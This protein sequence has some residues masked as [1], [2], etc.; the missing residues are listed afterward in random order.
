MLI[1]Q[2]INYNKKSY[3]LIFLSVFGL[4]FLTSLLGLKIATINDFASPVWI[5]SG[6][7]IGALAIYGLRIAPAIYISALLINFFAGM[8]LQFAAIVAFGNMT[9]AIIGGW[10]IILLTRKNY[11]KSYTE[12][13]AIFFSAL[14][15]TLISAAMGTYAS[16]IS[17]AVASHQISYAWYTWWSGDA[18]GTLIILPLVFE[19]FSVKKESHLRKNNKNLQTIVTFIVLGDNLPSLYT[20]P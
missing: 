4:Y 13:I 12:F 3:A 2:K 18:I 20:K 7:A 9:E 6:I 19:L 10:L 1:Q 17:G 16:Y 5:S 14:F 15:P 11:F 8:Q